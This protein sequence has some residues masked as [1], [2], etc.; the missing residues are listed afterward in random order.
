MAAPSIAGRCLDAA[1]GDGTKALLMAVRITR[2]R[3]IAHLQL[4][5]E[6]DEPLPVEVRHERNRKLAQ[7]AA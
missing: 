5:P 1:N 7:L 2:W 3:M 6:P 4:L